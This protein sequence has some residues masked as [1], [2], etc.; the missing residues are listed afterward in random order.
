M[1]KGKKFFEIKTKEEF[2]DF[3]IKTFIFQYRNNFIGYGPSGQNTTAR[4][5]F[6]ITL[7][8]DHSYPTSFNSGSTMPIRRGVSVLRID[9]NNQRLFTPANNVFLYD[10]TYTGSSSSAD[11]GGT[12]LKI[13]VTTIKSGVNA[14]D[15]KY[16]IHYF[17]DS[18]ICLKFEVDSVEIILNPQQSFHEY[19]QS[20]SNW[21]VTF[22]EDE[23]KEIWTAGYG[24]GLTGNLDTIAQM[25]CNPAIGGQAK[26]QIVREI[27]ALGGEMALNT[28]FTGIQFKLLN[29]SK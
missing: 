20:S 21:S 13:F 24:D 10:E 16:N 7:D 29:T 18:D 1:K 27:D 11:V 8:P 19:A 23:V 9:E 22:K 14:A 26:G 28:D 12:K 15:T 6:K 17:N 25:S 5:R 3:A 4:V 2:N